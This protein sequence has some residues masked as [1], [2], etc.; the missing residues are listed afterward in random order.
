MQHIS[1]FFREN[2]DYHARGVY[3]PPQVAELEAEF[4]GQPQRWL[5]G[6]FFPAMRATGAGQSQH[7]I[8]RPRRSRGVEPGSRYG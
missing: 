3:S 2:G 1:V 7:E 6:R 8:P 4:V 5:A